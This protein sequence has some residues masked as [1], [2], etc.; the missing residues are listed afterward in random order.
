MRFLLN[1]FKQLRSYPTALVGLG[2]IFSLIFLAFY[3]VI[4]I[5]YSEALR[6][7]RGGESVVAENPRNARPVWRNWFARE[8]WNPT[9]IVDTAAGEG[10][11]ESFEVLSD[12]IDEKIMTFSFDWDYDVF[13]PEMTFFLTADYDEK[14]PFVE[15]TWITPDGR[16]IRGGEVTPKPQEIYRPTLDDR[17][18]RRLDANSAEVGFFMNPEAADP[19]PVKGTYTVRVNA[20]LF[21]KD[22]DLEA[23][24]VMYGRVHGMA[25]TDHLRRDLSVALLW[26]TPLAMSFGLVAAIFTTMTTMTIA[27]IGVWYGGWVDAIIQRVTEVNLILPVLPILI[28]IGTLYSRSIWVILGSVIALGIFG[29]GIKTFRSIFLQVR[30]SPYIEAA[31][32]YGANS[33]RVIFRYLVPRVIPL[34]IPALVSG[35]PAF[36]FLEASLAVLNL[37]DPVLP[38]WGKIISDA[39]SEGALFNGYYYWILEPAA[40]LMLTGIGFAMVGFALDRIFNPRLREV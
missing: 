12:D 28:M 34:I 11:E 15:F 2:I 17:V 32:S 8:T 7:W 38:T 22:A 13:A 29:G 16:E 14:A 24:L 19:T 26:G 20:L 40:L 18:M 30:E 35:V 31:Q 4:T 23:K 33:T 27:A 39:N 21:E 25:G 10:I 6:L 5:P 9:I 37:G 36:V 1:T 3:A